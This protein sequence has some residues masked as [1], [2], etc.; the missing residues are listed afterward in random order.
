[1]DQ[2]TRQRRGLL[3]VLSSPSGA[4]KSTIARMLLEADDEVT[5]SISATTRPI[6]PGET[7][8]LDYHFVDDDGFDA[9][10]DDGEFVE[11]AP[12]F[13]YRYGTPKAP[14][15]DALRKGRDILFDIDWQG[16]Q[17]L[18]GAFGTDLVR[19]FVLP[20][21]M[22]ELERRLRARGT[23]SEDV[24]ESRMRRAASEIGHW[25]EYDYVLINEDMDHCLAEV[26]AIIDAERL[27]RDRRPYLFDFVRRL[28]ERPNY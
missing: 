4:G 5:M 11:W 3:I 24:I 20:P 27:R 19:I 17:Q 6:R 8:D 10:I 22:Q 7:D 12:V 18:R 25:G 28:V 14:V 13:G 26:R 16:T 21:S 23:D 15:K 9:M 2:P 1:M